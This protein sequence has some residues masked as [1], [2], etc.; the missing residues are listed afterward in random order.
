MTQARPEIG[1]VNRPVP[2]RKLT[3]QFSNRAIV[4]SAFSAA[5]LIGALVAPAI[6]LIGFALAFLATSAF[7]ATA[8][9]CACGW[10]RAFAIGAFFPHG[11]SYLVL[12]A[13]FRG[14]EEVILAICL[15]LA[16][17]F[18]VGGVAAVVHGFFVRR[19]GKI[20]VPN[21]PLIRTLLTNDTI[22]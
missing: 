17:S 14:P 21:L 16:V 7:L 11:L 19:G 13:G 20:A 8:I 9:F 3:I 10:F 1:F 18:L 12:F 4:F 6:S 5:I 15:S 2:P 22:Q